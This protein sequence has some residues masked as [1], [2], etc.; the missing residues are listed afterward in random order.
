MSR[1]TEHERRYAVDDRLVMPESRFEVVGGEVRYVSPA[2]QPHASLHSKLSA[3]LEAYVAEGWDAASDML[4][5]TAEKEDF[6]PD[7]S[8]YPV[9][10]DPETGGRQLEELAFEVVS[11]ESIAHAGRKAAALRQRGVRRVF[12]IDVERKRA[13]EWSTATDAWQMLAPDAEIRDR[14]L[15][16]GLPVAALVA[17]AKTDDAIAR[18]LL[19]KKN[20]VLSEAL[21]S[22]A[23]E[24]K[25]EGRAEGKAEAVLD[26]LRARTVPVDAATEARVL[27]LRDPDEVSRCLLRA[28]TCNRAAELFED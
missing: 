1:E 18:A 7:G 25:A 17:A 8:V 27:A 11:T 23:A 6:A 24:G 16:T 20:A 28:A 5:R 13:L 14:T 9:A 21:E 12:A 26:L 19:A 3:L 22:R 4:T 10:P 2:E 15:V